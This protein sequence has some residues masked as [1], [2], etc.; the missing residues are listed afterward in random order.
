MSEEIFL[1]VIIPAYNEE[2]R[3]PKTLQS[4]DAYL[5]KQQWSYEVIVVS[6]GSKDRTAEVARELSSQMPYLRVIDNKENHGK[7][8]VV[9]QG[10]MEA[11]GKYRLFM[12]ADNATS[13]DQVEKMLPLL[14]QGCGFKVFSEDAVRKIFPLLTINRWAFDV[15]I[16]AVAK[17]LGIKIKEAP[18]VWVNDPNS[19]VKFSGMVKMLFEVLQV[20][21]N[22]LTNKYAPHQ[23]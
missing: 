5:R 2:K 19:Q 11:K 4:V 13:V 21:W 23:K 12:D 9:R 17:K 14:E 8:Y 3:L 6:D 20:R 10:I 7:G 22:L 16:L 18:V 1:S 15:E